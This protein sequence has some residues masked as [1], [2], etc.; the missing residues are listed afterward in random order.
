MSGGPTEIELFARIQVGDKEAMQLLFQREYLPICRTIRRFIADSATVEDL[1]QD[2]FLRL[3]TKRTGIVVNSSLSAYLRRMAVN[4][5]L[6]YLR[7]KRTFLEEEQIP[8]LLASAE[9]DTEER[10]FYR[11]LDHQVRKAIDELPPRC[12]AIFQLSRFE[13]MSYQEIA[14]ELGLSVKT[15]EN[16]MGK[17]LKHLRARLQP[18]LK[19]S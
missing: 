11:E 9:D 4:E 17:A 14:N 2:V 19:H 1:A 15:V 10:F 18:Y 12:R 7:R 16:Q 5:A 3:W 13:E 6:G 8:I